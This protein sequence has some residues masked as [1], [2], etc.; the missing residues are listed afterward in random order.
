M[1]DQLNPVAD[2]LVAI[3]EASMAAR[4]MP[5]T[6]L[7]RLT[8]PSMHQTASVAGA[9]LVPGA[10]SPPPA[11]TADS[12][13]PA[14]T[15]DGPADPACI[16]ASIAAGAEEDIKLM[17]GSW[18]TYYFSD[19][20]M[21]EAYA[22][23]LFRIAE[24]DPAKLVADTVRDESR[25]YPRPTAAATFLETPFRMTAAE[26]DGVLWQIAQRSDMSDIKRTN[27]SNGALYL[28]SSHYLIDVHAD[29]LAEWIEVGQLENP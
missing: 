26:L 14:A 18:D 24:K 17:R 16:A 11:A 13:A 19:H 10:V 12:S 4:L 7:C 2:L 25:I 29:S 8:V 23:H 20:H 1:T 3:R 28:Y 15:A 6:E 5:L 22:L 9:D 27:A 21:T